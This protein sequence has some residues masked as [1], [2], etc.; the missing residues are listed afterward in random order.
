MGYGPWGHKELD[1][2]E[3][4]WHACTQA[5]GVYAFQ[6]EA[7][8]PLGCAPSWG[9]GW[10]GLAPG[11][12]EGHPNTPRVDPRQWSSGGWGVGLLISVPQG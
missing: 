11:W 9:Q 12:Q 7:G 6:D 1:M 3:G 10:A 4:T 2:T 8:G 5:P